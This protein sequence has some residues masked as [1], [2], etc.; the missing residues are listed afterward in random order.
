[1]N[2]ECP[3]VASPPVNI[4]V[5]TIMYRIWWFYSAIIAFMVTETYNVKKLLTKGQ[6]PYTYDVIYKKYNVFN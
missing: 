2:F 4:F 5:I 6:R 1:M 3:K